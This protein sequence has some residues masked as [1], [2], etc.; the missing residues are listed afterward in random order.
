[1]FHQTDEF[2]FFNVIFYFLNSSLCDDRW[3]VV[4][5]VS[6]NLVAVRIQLFVARFIHN[7]ILYILVRPSLSGMIGINFGPDLELCCLELKRY[8]FNPHV[9]H[10]K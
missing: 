10:I 1:M 6:V 2:K 3:I 5:A 7:F 8:V 4:V 9:S